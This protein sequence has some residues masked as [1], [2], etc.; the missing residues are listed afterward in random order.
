MKLIFEDERIQK[1]Y[2]D[3]ILNESA[4]RQIATAISKVFP[5]KVKKI[6]EKKKVIFHLSSF[7]DQEDFDNFNKIDAVDE[8]IKKKFK[9]A[10][11]EWKG[12]TIEVTEL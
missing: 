4:E 8:L 7:V 9:D 1:A 11:V 6:E 12:Y 10:I 5:V 2:E 3:S